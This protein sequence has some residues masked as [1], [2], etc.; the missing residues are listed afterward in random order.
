MKEVKWFS[1]DNCEYPDIDESNC[2]DVWLI[3]FDG[4]VEH[5]IYSNPL[6]DEFYFSDVDCEKL[7][8]VTQWARF[9]T[10]D[11]PVK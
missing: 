3:N 8:G 10:P 2:V 11:G 1:T 9:T 6:M 5:G 4:N 7:D